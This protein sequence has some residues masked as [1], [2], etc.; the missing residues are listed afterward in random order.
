MSTTE[1]PPI[2]A[3]MGHVDHGKS[4]LLDYIRK[5]N[6]VDTE[7]GGITQHVSAYEVTHTTDG[8]AKKITFLDTPGH[9]AFSAIRNRSAK[10]ADIAI[11]VVAAD[12]GVKP[13]TVEAFESIKKANTPFVIAINKVD[14]P[15]ANI[16]QVKANLAENNIFVE[17]YGGDV[18]FVAVSAI[19]GTGVS[20]LL[21]TILLVAEME[22]FKGNTE[23]SATGFIVESKLDAQKGISATLL[24]KNGTLNTNTFVVTDNNYCPVRYIEN[25]LGKQIESGTLSQPVVVTGWSSLPS[26]GEEFTIVNTKKEAEKVTDQTHKTSQSN[27]A[28]E[29]ANKKQV[30]LILKSDAFGSLDAVIQEIGK[31]SFERI[32]PQIIFAGIGPITEK[33]IQL[34]HTKENSLIIG[35][36]VDTE[37]RAKHMVDR[38]GLTAHTFNIIYKLTE[39]LEEE[40]VR[41]TPLV[42][43]DEVT[44]SA[45]ILKIFSKTKDKQVVGGRM[46]EGILKKGSQVRI[47]RR[48]NEIGTGTIKELQQQKTSVTEIS[49][50]SEFGTM[51]ESKV[52]IVA[53]DTVQSFQRV[54]K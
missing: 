30:P 45:K 7:S 47:M 5:S 2:I 46:E 35:F 44:G 51:I 41:Q 28:P 34:A 3:V 4:T 10:V 53:G 23:V 37:T 6:V 25:F 40:L 38:E 20:D 24:I 17:G 50:G 39:W 21:D 15:E 12:D 54:K 1:R 22:S 33:D 27:I 16:E 31:L 13:Q 26:A 52:E 14:K 18:P 43:T 11:L 32:S 9:A 49:E 42:E 29:D 36:N 8:V 48:E 19:E